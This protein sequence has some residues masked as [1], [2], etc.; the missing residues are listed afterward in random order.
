VAAR[1]GHE[2]PRAALD[3]LSLGG[4]ANG[5][6]REDGFDIT[7]ASEVMAIFC[8]ASDLDDLKQR[9]S[10]I[11]VAY[12]RDPL[13]RC[14]PADLKA[15]GPMTGAA[16][17]EALAPNL[18]QTLEGTPAFIHGGPVRQHRP[19]LQFGAGNDDRAQAL[20]LC[21]NRMRIRRRSRR[22]RNSSTSSAARPGLRRTARCWSRPSARS[23]CTAAVKKEDLKTENLKALG[24]GMANLARHVENVQK[25]GIVPVISINRFS[26]DTDAEIALVEGA[27]QEARR[28]GLHGRPLGRGRQGAADVARAW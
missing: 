26:A 21:R 17:K 16:C 13:N 25:F 7:V 10:K 22:L 15:H 28:R 8:L 5:F 4:V 20:R 27:R 18:V 11:V 23:R 19:R 9:L 14:A 3:R 6:P 2:R 12:T 1:A 24:A